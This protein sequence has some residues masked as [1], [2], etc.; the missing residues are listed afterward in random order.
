MSRVDFTTAEGSNFGAQKILPGQKGIP[1]SSWN[2]LVQ[3]TNTTRTLPSEGGTGMVSPYGNLVASPRKFLRTSPLTPFRVIDAS[4]EGV[5]K[6]RV[7]FGF[8]N[9][10]IPTIGGIPLDADPAPT[11]AIA[12]DCSVYLKTTWTGYEPKL[13]DSAEIVALTTQPVDDISTGYKRLSDV[14]ISQDG[15]MRILTGVTYSLFVERLHCYDEEDATTG[16][17]WGGV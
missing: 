8:L 12:S 15:G 5:K 9:N 14:R 13:L 11:I 16:Y 1:A 3:A 4:T 6:V 7:V 17:F 10:I 2:R